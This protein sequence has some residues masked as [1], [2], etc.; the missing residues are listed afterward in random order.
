[1]KT[2][3]LT[4]L[5]SRYFWDSRCFQRSWKNSFLPVLCALKFFGGYVF[6]AIID[7][8]RILQRLDNEII[9]ELFKN[10]MLPIEIILNK[11]LY[12]SGFPLRLSWLN[13]AN[14]Q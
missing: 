5:D 3:F 9:K 14:N 7:D 13:K 6:D 1:M 12:L 2:V 8:V 4:A 10:F 11:H